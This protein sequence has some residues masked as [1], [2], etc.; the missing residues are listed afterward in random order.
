MAITALES[1]LQWIDEANPLADT[2]AEAVDPRVRTAMDLLCRRLNERLTVEDLADACC[3]SASRLAH[4]FREQV[5]QSPMRF[6]EA[7]RIRRARELLEH[8]ALGVAEISDRVGFESPFYFS[9][10]FSLAVGMSPRAYRA[11]VA[12]E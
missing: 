9:R 1:A 12:R 8:S 2:A 10:R 7:Q 3:L 5:G 4:L 11:T 6:L